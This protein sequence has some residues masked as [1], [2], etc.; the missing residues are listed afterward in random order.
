MTALT[1][2][3]LSKDYGGGAALRGFSL[4]VADGELVAIVGPSGC[5]KSTLLRTVAGLEEE[6]SGTV[7]LGGRVLNGLAP[8]DR[9]VALMFQSYTL[10]PH[11]TVAENLAF[12]LKLRGTPRA[13][14]EAAARE[15][16][17]LL[18]I[19]NLLARLP[20]EISGGE[21]QRVAL[22]RSILRSP[23]AFL[24]DEPL[25]SLDAQMRLQLR[26]E[27][28]RLHQRM[29]V[30]MLF[31][32]HDQNE[33]LTLGDRVVVLNQGVIQQVSPPEE[34]YRRPANAFVASFIG[35]PGMNLFAG[36]VEEDDADLGL[37]FVSPA[38]SFPVPR[39]R[40][41]LLRGRGAVTAGIRPE[42]LRPA[43]GNGAAPSEAL[44]RGEVTAAERQAGQTTLY[45]QQ[46]A[47]SFAARVAGDF[48]A[49]A[50]E[51]RS[52]SFDPADL[53]FFDAE[54]GAIR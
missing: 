43:G 25:S 49:H 9:D 14:R 20:A 42:H 44:L 7:R 27:I 19:E 10:L 51:A 54:G 28:Q 24:F 5:G 52:W 33:A 11:L 47:I 46:G 4:E 18:G 16:A 32:T 45:Q 35:A 23:Q 38:L 39:D 40:E 29:R 15:T 21:R 8:R 30:P 36:R 37:R 3:N 48:S 6:T 13:K 2:E 50:G 41:A 53:F 12:G 1:I 17:R 31:V 26:V 34:L 22:G